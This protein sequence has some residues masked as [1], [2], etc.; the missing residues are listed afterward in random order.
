M[1]YPDIWE[2]WGCDIWEK[3]GLVRD[4]HLDEFVGHL[5][6][7]VVRLGEYPFDRRRLGE[8]VEERLAPSA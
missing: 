3:M 1:R 7:I 8:R 4:T 2:E 6:R 5:L